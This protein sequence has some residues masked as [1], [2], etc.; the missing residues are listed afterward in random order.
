MKRGLII[1]IS[2]LILMIIIGIF[3]YLNPLINPLSNCA[4][5]GKISLNEVTGES[6]KCCSGLKEIAGFPKNPPPEWIVNLSDEDCQR[7]SDRENC[8]NIIDPY[9][10]GFSSICSDCGNKVCEGWEN[11][12]N[13]PKDCS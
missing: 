12:Y 5:A 2:V 8:L 1:V 3:L 6:K 13:C 4:G 7:F 10:V 9:L 11:I